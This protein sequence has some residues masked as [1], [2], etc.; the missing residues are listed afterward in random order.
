V[1]GLAGL[2]LGAWVLRIK[3][4]SAERIAKRSVLIFVLSSAASAAGVVV[5]GLPMWLG[6]LPG[7]TDPLLTL[8]PAGVALAAILATIGAAAAAGRMARSRGARATSGGGSEGG[9]SGGDGGSEGDAGGGG[10]EGGAHEPGELSRTALALLAISEG[11]YGALGLIRRGDPRLLGAIGYWV[12][13]ALTLYAALAAFGHVPPFWPVAM[14]Y[15][16]GM[17]ANSAPV[18]GGFGAV[19]GGLVGMLDLFDVAPGSTVIAAVVVYRAI[20]LWI[21]ALIG[22]VAFLSLRREIDKPQAALGA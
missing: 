14:A 13:D 8:L 22:A 3:G 18:P 21:P 9:A 11:V 2:A 12:F 4:F 15:L 6:L 1:S 19:E 17:L 16:V 10:A 5:I 7:S 20:S